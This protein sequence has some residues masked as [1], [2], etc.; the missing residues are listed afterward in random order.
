[1]AAPDPSHVGRNFVEFYFKMLNEKPDS[2]WQ[3]YMDNA[4]LSYA[5]EG[6]KEEERVQGSQAIQTLLSNFKY[7]ESRPTCRIT[8]LACQEGP[9]GSVVVMITGQLDSSTGAKSESKLGPFVRTFVLVNVDGRFWIAND[10]FRSLAVGAVDAKFSNRPASSS[11]NQRKDKKSGRKDTGKS[12]SEET[13]DSEGD[14][15]K[16]VASSN[17]AGGVQQENIQAAAKQACF[18]FRLSLLEHDDTNQFVF[19][20]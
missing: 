6:D 3:F 1:M 9:A 8:V 16:A 14:G 20:S 18:P 4:R 19:F 17:D 12:A 7:E 13:V 11:T 5:K 2:I 15:K 10:V